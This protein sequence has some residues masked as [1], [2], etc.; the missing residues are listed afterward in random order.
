MRP[1]VTPDPDRAAELQRRMTALTYY[2][3]NGFHRDL[4]QRRQASIVPERASRLVR[5]SN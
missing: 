2:P 1:R 4:R 5:A 3:E